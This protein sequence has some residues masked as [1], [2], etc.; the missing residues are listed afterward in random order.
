[1]NFH[2]MRKI[3]KII[4]GILN[5]PKKQTKKTEKIRPNSTMILSRSIFFWFV[6]LGE[7]YVQSQNE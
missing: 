6:F 5:S 7:M 1:M 2:L 3:S 4:Y